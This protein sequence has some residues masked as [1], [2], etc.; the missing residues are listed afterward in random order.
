MA[1]L[2]TQLAYLVVRQD[3]GNSSDQT[4]AQE[5]TT[6]T[7]STGNEYDGRIGVRISAIFVILIG[8]MLG[9][10]AHRLSTTIC[11]GLIRNVNR[12][13]VP[14]ICR[15]PSWY[16]SAGLGVLHCEIFW[17]GRDYRDCFHTCK[18]SRCCYSGLT[19]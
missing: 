16:R 13:V 11:A 12:R 6:D 15:T 2:A 3:G 18:K 14:N 1:E 10:P 9:M 19:S 8:S 5:D 4:G 17:V 7:C